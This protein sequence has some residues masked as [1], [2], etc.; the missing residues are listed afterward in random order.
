MRNKTLCLCMIVRN[1][2]H[3]ILE[4]L[5]SVKHCLDYWVICDT[6]S[7]DNTIELIQN[8]FDEE[9]IKGEIHSDTWVNFG[10]NR[11]RAFEFAMNKADYLLVMDADDVLVGQMNLEQLEADSYSLRYGD[12]FTYWRSQLFKGTEKWMYKGVLHEYPVCLSKNTPTSGAVE[13][14][15]HII[16]RRLGARNLVEPV[17]KYLGDAHVI[18]QALQQE[19]DAE[20]KTRYLFYLAQSYRDA[21]RH[22]LAIDWYKKRIEAGGWPEEVWRSKYEIG[23]LYEI[24]GDPERAKQFYLAAFEYRPSRAESLYS[25]GKMCNERQDFFQ[26][27]L[28]LEHAS[29]IPHTRDSLFV[30]KN[31]YDHEILFQLSISYYWTGDYA[32]SIKLCE[33]L[34]T[35]KDRVPAEIYEQTLK[36]MA[37]GV[38]KSLAQ[39]Q[40]G[41]HSVIE[42][43]YMSTFYCGVNSDYK[44]LLIGAGSNRVKKI[45][46]NGRSEWT[47]LIS[48]DINSDHHP[49]VVWNLENLPLPFEDNQFDEIHAYEVLEHTGQ[50]GDYVFFFAQFSEFWRILKP[51]GYLIGTC[52][53]RNSP[54]AWGDPSHKRIFQPENLVFLDQSE[55]IRQVGITPMSDFR[56]IYKA[57]FVCSHSAD[58]NNTFSFVIQAVKPSRISSPVK[59]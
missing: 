55:Y 40:A 22:E 2:S 42:N 20:L 31:V 56:Y 9:G 16:S 50:Q 7:T 28:F 30:S 8:F 34:I 33:K 35:M 10:H 17:T 52:P 19:T 51:G 14:N 21:G 1:E 4:T 39:H 29:K 26:A 38:E 49:D 58:D 57:D 23:L 44:E 12:S 54:W 13:G 24:L 25:L 43:K 11:S 36:N 47:Q 53:S 45:I 27:C 6:G 3:I 5:N 15:Y 48:L 18:E 59:I 46:M 32:M 41:I 37:F